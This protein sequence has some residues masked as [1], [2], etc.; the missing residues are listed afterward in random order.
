MSIHVDLHVVC[1]NSAC[2]CKMFN[3]NEKD[4]ADQPEMVLFECNLTKTYVRIHFRCIQAGLHV[5]CMN[6]A[7]NCNI[8][9][10]YG[11]DHAD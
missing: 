5:V 2:I 7:H 10:N 1:M 4:H 11:K 6:S 9:N 8:F 3:N